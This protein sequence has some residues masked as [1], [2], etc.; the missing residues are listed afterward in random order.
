MSKSTTAFDQ[1]E[2]RVTSERPLRVI[3][4]PSTQGARPAGGPR[5]GDAAWHD[6]PPAGMNAEIVRIDLRAYACATCPRCKKR[7]RIA[8]QHNNHGEYRIL[9]TCATHGCHFEEAF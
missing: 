9:G 2:Q 1:E 7:L 5:K 3:M 6:G 4:R 8:A